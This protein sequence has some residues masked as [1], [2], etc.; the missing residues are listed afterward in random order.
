MSYLNQ[1]LAEFNYLKHLVL[2]Y[3]DG[4]NPWTKERLKYY[5]AHLCND[6][7]PDDWLFDSF[8]FINTKSTS[9]RDYV[10]DINLGKSMSGEGDFFTICSPNPANKLDWENLLDFYFGEDG[11]LSTLDETIK[12]L[13]GVI[14]T[15]S[16]KCCP[17]PSLSTYNSKGIRH[18]QSKWENSKLLSH[19][20]KPHASHPIAT[21][22]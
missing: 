1:N 9:G 19:W 16:P 12:E 20:P 18:S 4:K 10:A 7:K 17:N 5:V 15:K 6:G 22:S 21:G 11:A 13:S 8:L 2:L 14:T 3:G